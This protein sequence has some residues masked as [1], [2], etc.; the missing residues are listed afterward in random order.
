MFDLFPRVILSGR[1]TT[2]VISGE[3]VP[4]GAK[5]H[6]V[7]YSMESYATPH[8]VYLVDEQ[9]CREPI[10]ATS[11]GGC[12]RFDFTPEGEQRHRVV[13]DLNGNRSEFELYSLKEDL[14]RLNAYK[15]DTHVHTT[16]SDGLSSPLDTMIAY[17]AAGFDYIAITDHHT[18]R[19]SAELARKVHGL[20]HFHVYPGEEVH[21]RGMGYFHIIGFGAE[22]SVNELINPREDELF[23]EICSAKNEIAQR[24]GLP[25]GLDK[26]EFAF[27]VWVSQK[28]R[29]FGGISVLCHPYWDAYGTYN[30]QT[31]MLEFLLRNRI[32]DAFE[33]VD[34]TD[35]T[36][37]GCNLQVAIYNEMRASGIRIPII[38]ASDCH[39][40]RSAVFGKFFT[41][42]FCN[43]VADVKEAVKN[44]STVAVEKIGD[45]YRVHGTF[46]LVKYARFIID[47]FEPCERKLRAELAERL[48]TGIEEGDWKT[49]GKIE[50]EAVGYRNRFFGRS[51]PVS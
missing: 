41:Y 1:K 48:K 9:V 8:T 27:R 25:E 33:V 18:Y 43:D 30:M 40:V 5:A 31:E 16:A 23:A 3:G 39:D 47:N 19:D 11:E 10:E 37:N 24:Y 15:G 45:E 46:R 21:N 34:D 44:A 22:K 13:C 42:A 4:N 35:G 36:G 20:K 26:S 51:E 7:V 17:Y 14:Y 6:I 32:F 29:E 38:G 2:L 28:I 50:K 49:V 12:I